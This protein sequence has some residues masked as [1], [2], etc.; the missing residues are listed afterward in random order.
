MQSLS[1]AAV[2]LLSAL[3]L[4][5]TR[6]KL[7]TSLIMMETYS[8]GPDGISKSLLEQKSTNINSL[9]KTIF[10]MWAEQYFSTENYVLNTHTHTQAFPIHAMPPLH[11]GFY[12]PT[13]TA[14]RSFTGNEHLDFTTCRNNPPPQSHV[15]N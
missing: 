14:N 6:S 10:G 13:T 15:P 2:T 12:Y 5:I 8:P 4:I 1:I 9:F 3:A 7:I 11:K